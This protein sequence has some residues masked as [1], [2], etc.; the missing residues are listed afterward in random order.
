MRVHK[1][2]SLS[3]KRA[4]GEGLSHGVWTW[5]KYISHALRSLCAVLSGLVSPV[6]QAGGEGGRELKGIPAQRKVMVTRTLSAG[7]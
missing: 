4:K 1:G 3:Q 6:T 7:D 5:G 2:Q